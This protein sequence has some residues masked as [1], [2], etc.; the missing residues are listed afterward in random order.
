V[1]RSCFESP[2]SYQGGKSRIADAIADLIL[3]ERAQAFRLDDPPSDVFD[4][5]CGSGAVSIALVKKGLLPELIT[6]VDAGP[7]GLFWREVG[8]GTFDLDFF[9]DIAASVPKNPKLICDYMEATCARRVQEDRL[10]YDFLCLQAASF[11]SKPI[12]IRT[13]D[14]ATGMQ[15]APM[16]EHSGFRDFWE[17]T[18]TSKRRSHVNPMMPMPDT[19]VERMAEIV[20]HMRGVKGCQDDAKYVTTTPK[21][22]VYCDP[23][24]SGGSMAGYGCY[25]FDPVARVKALTATGRTVLVSEQKA[26]R[27]GTTSVKI[28]DPRMKGGISGKRQASHPEWVTIF[29]P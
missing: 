4:L 6:M 20:V 7:W 26:L 12:T 16:W 25:F 5:C 19:I 10:V 9:K 29:R 18:K 11:G 13:H 17:P 24:Y 1:T 14:K 8:C 2:V 3:R 27:G 21:A 22:T 23:P 15:T 28:A